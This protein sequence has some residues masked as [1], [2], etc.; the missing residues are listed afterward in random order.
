MPS[1]LHNLGLCYEKGLGVPADEAEAKR[2]YAL[3]AAQGFEK[4]IERLKR[5]DGDSA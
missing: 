4:A 5:F 3:A 1:S 2:Y